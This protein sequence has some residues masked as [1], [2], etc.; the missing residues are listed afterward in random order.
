MRL[1]LEKGHLAELSDHIDNI[2]ETVT[3]KDYPIITEIKNKMYEFGALTSLMS[4]SG[5]TVF[6]FFQNNFYARKAFNYFRN[7]KNY[8]KQVFLTNPYQP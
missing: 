8:G 1:A 3:V 7:H 2:L 5:P 4:G 6:A